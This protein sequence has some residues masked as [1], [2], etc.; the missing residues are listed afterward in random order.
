MPSRVARL[1]E[2]EVS[3]ESP[4][5]VLARQNREMAGV[6]REVSLDMSDSKAPV[7]IIALR[8]AAAQL[9]QELRE[10]GDSQAVLEFEAISAVFERADA[11]ASALRQAEIEGGIPFTTTVAGDA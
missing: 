11:R 6:L 3:K 5:A 10:S 2:N 8:A 1:G 9:E 4:A 7:A